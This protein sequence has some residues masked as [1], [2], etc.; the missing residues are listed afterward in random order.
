MYFGTKYVSP[1]GNVLVA[2]DKN[3]IIGLWLSE[4][5]YLAKTKP[6]AITLTDKQPL[7]KKA[8][9]WLDAY[10]AGKRPKPEKLPLAPRGNEFQQLVW[11]ILLTIP[12]GTT[13]TYGAIAKKVA[14]S[15]GKEKMS[16]Q[17][18]GG[19]VGHN[20]IGIIIPCHRVVGADGN[21]TGYAGG[22]DKK[23]YLLKHEG[24]DMSKL[25][26]PKI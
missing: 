24:V 4:Q 12:Y 18:V 19:A 14:V 17:A 23:L 16:A 7:L 21:L 20:P 15:M 5:K 10:F 25:Y 1:I 22:L 26:M 2:C 9:L 8:V 11:K 6:V 3:H 13:T